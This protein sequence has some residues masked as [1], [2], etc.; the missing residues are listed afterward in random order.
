MNSRTLRTFELGLAPLVLALVPLACGSP[1]PGP[2]DGQG[3][4]TG[5]SVIGG[6]GGG[7]STGSGGGNS[8][9]GGTDLGSSTGAGSG[10]LGPSEGGIVSLTPEELA[11]LEDG[12]AC[13]GWTAEGENLPAIL[14]FVVDT[15][16]SMNTMAPGGDFGE[17]RWTVTRDALRAALDD[18][19]GSVAAGILFYPNM[20][21]SASTTARPV[22][23]C[24][25]VDEIL[26]IDVLGEAASAQRTTLD[27]ALATTEP[28]GYTPTE[29]AYRYALTSSLVPYTGTT[30]DKF[31]VLLTDGAP[32]MA[33]GCITAPA[34]VQC[35]Q[36]CGPTPPATACPAGCVMGGGGGMLA[37]VPTQP[38]VDEIT[39]AFGQGVRTFLIGAPGS[40][41]GSDGSDK[42]PWLS[43]GA[44]EGGTP[45]DGCMEAGPAFCHMDMTQEAD[46]A[47]ALTEGLRA[48]AT[49]VVNTCSF[50]IPDPPDGHELD[51]DD[52]SL[53]VKW[54]DG[55]GSA[56]LRDS[57]GDC[58][59]GW[60]LD[61]TGTQI[62]LCPASC[63]QLKAS[64]GATVQLSF[65]CL[66]VIK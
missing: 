53:V 5:G 3:P 16:L 37:D 50:V 24:I 12:S 57:V 40:E 44:I 25:A 33:E 48:I 2:D 20:A 30:G 27:D 15:S 35:P 32:T 54:A 46:F 45:K 29:D 39:A 42:R 52:T 62:D 65:G 14:Q 1:A 34:P 26:P 28:N 55:T 31:M 47:T 11:A 61:A 56:Y 19:P 58:G 43:K 7:S 4:G 49:A 66:D 64:P 23:E 51:L 41:V 9:I 21:N 22:E 17:T 13:Q 60:S 63:E 8:T 36:G 6:T 18:L 59:E 38:I 10:S